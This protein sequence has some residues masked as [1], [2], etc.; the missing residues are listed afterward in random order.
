MLPDKSTRIFDA[1]KAIEESTEY[2]NVYNHLS[3]EA[4]TLKGTS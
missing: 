1:Q 2:Q 3:A 4:T